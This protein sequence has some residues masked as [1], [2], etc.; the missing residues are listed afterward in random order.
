[1]LIRQVDRGA[2]IFATAKPPCSREKLETLF[3]KTQIFSPLD[4]KVLDY[5]LR[6]PYLGQ[7]STRYVFLSIIHRND[8]VLAQNRLRNYFWLL[9][10]SSA[11]MKSASRLGGLTKSLQ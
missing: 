7:H 11:R 6:S 9:G 2:K 1:M 5:S 4:I 8:G 10:I 3:N